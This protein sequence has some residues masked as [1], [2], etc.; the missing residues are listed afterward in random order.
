MKEA[1]Y[2]EIVE[3]IH[4]TL[5]PLCEADPDFELVWDFVRDLWSEHEEYAYDALVDDEE[6]DEDIEEGE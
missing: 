1:K 5:Q 3:K 6:I 4:E 2:S